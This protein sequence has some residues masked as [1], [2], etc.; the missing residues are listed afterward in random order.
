[1]LNMRVHAA[2]AQQSEEMQLPCPPALHRLL[3]ERHVLQL[4]VRDQQVDPRNVHVHDSSRAM[5]MCPT[6]LLPICPSGNPTNGPEYESA[7]W[8]I[9]ESARHT[10]ASVP[11]PPRSPSSPREIPIHPARSAQSVSVV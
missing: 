5:F 8:E 4:L 11:T 3:K 10:P 7:Y 9:C 1:M 2:V 6:S